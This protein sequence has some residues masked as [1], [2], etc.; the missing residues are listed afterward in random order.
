M[1]ASQQQL[2]LRV[3]NRRCFLRKLQNSKKPLTCTALN[4]STQSNQQSDWS[5]SQYLKFGGERA[6]PTTDLLA[7]VPLEAPK[8]IIDL[9]C[10]PGNS[11][12]VLS[13]RY[14]DADILGMDSSDDMLEK[15]R[16]TLPNVKFIKADLETYVPEQPV[17]LLFSNAVFHWL[18]DQKRIPVMQNL[19]GSLA[20]GGVFAIQVP[21]NA[22]EP[23]HRIMR[24]VAESQGPWVSRLRELKPALPPF[25]DF[26]ILYK[27]LKPLCSKLDI[28][29]THYYHVLKDHQAIVE[30]VKGTGLRPFI[31]PLPEEQRREFQEKYLA[32]ITNAYRPLEHDGQVVLKYPRLFIV[33]VRA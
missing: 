20:P 13:Q 8:R 9:G 15:A 6:V 18:P 19:L 33:A 32:E 26:R 17:D 16:A 14:P 2:A 7:K 5:S 3:M 10:G 27:H 11:T 24:D 29:H 31:D 22:D 4:Y 12:A 28:W 30:W 25:P 21:D 23:S 1:L